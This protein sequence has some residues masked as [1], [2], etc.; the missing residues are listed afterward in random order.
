MTEKTTED[1]K[2]IVQLINDIRND[3]EIQLRE[4]E[5]KRQN[6][7]EDLDSKYNKILK[8]KQDSYLDY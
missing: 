8:E 4:L 6:D 7:Q 2:L 1:Y 3:S 5:I